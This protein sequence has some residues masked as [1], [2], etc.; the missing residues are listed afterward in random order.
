MALH[1]DIRVN[2]E[3]IGRWSAQRVLT[4]KSGWHEYRWEAVSNGER[5]TGVLGHWYDNG[6]LML[7]Q[8][9]LIAAH[10]ELTRN[11]T[12]ATRPQ[13][14]RCVTAEA[15]AGAEG[16]QTQPC[17]AEREPREMPSSGPTLPADASHLVRGTENRGS[18]EAD[19]DLA[20]SILDDARH[21]LSPEQPGQRIEPAK[22]V[23]WS[24][25]ACRIVREWEDRKRR[26]SWQPPAHVVHHEAET[27]LPPEDREGL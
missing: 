13:G 25:D 19:L 20:A 14:P 4:R 9:V 1:G 7:A 22:R 12:G 2:G 11:H 18:G 23:L 17:P 27:Y 3:V 8:A 15:L 6:A 5:V 10:E 26:A 21:A 16:P 24:E